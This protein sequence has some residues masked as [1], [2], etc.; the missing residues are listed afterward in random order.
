MAKKKNNSVW[1]WIGGA[2]A[3]LWLSWRGL[4]SRV[5]YRIVGL[6]PVRVTADEAVFNLVMQL[7][8][9]S[10]IKALVGDMYANVYINGC[11]VGV[12]SYPVNRYLRPRQVNQFT[13]QVTAR[14]AQ[15]TAVLWQQ[16]TS[17]YFYN[18][19]FDM[20]GYIDVE[21]RQLRVS[22]HFVMEDLIRR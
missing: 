5:R 14:P 16:L 20:R 12:V 8:N 9:P 18:M 7:Y 3:L 15:L 1:W 21:G 11:H 22:L 4:L 6:V 19:D 2:A 17:G 13:V 10:G